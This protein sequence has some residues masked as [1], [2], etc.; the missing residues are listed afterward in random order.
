MR[1]RVEKLKNTLIRFLRTRKDIYKTCRYLR[2]PLDEILEFLRF[3]TVEPYI[4]K[5]AMLLDIGTG[6]SNFYATLMDICNLLWVLIHIPDKL[7]IA[8]PVN[9][10]P[11][12][13]YM[14]L[15]KMESSMSSL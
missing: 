2:K 10:F 15:L 7:S 5:D 6:N 8:P 1:E 4:P 12:T 11:A 3:T 14:T 13:S 9:S